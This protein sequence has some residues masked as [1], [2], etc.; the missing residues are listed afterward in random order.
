M[1]MYYDITMYYKN[2]YIRKEVRNIVA[3]FQVYWKSSKFTT[4]SAHYA[5]VVVRL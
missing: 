5:E 4:S 1:S 3:D 2:A